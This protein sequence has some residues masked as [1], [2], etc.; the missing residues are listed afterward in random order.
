MILTVLVALNLFMVVVMRV[1]GSQ[2]YPFFISVYIWVPIYVSLVS[3]LLY[4]ENL[5]R[6]AE[7]AG[8]FPIWMTVVLTVAVRLLFVGQTESISLDAL[9]Y[10]DFGRFMQMGKIPYAG[11]YFPYPPVFAYFIFVII[12]T[13]PSVDS[14]RVL[15]ACTDGC[16]VVVLFGL[17]RQIHHSSWS[18]AIALSYALLPM[19]IIESG[20]NGHFEP[21]VV[22]LTLLSMWFVLKGRT[23]L[24]GV[25]LGL[26]VATKIYPIALLP[27]YL[28]YLKQWR[29]RIE[30]TLAIVTSIAATFIPILAVGW[31]GNGTAPPGESLSTQSLLGLLLSLLGFISNPNLVV[32]TANIFLIAAIA[33]GI[34]LT[35]FQFVRGNTLSYWHE[36]QWVMLFLGLFLVTAGLIA[37][38][39][40]L[41][42]ESRLVFWRYP[43]DVAIVRGVTIMSTG[44]VV[45]FMAYKVRRQSG[46]PE[47]SSESLL[48][49]VSATVLL[50]LALSREDFFGWYLLWSAPL[51][52]LVRN[53]RLG[54]TVLFCLL[55]AYP[56]YTHDNFVSLGFEEQ[57]LW[58][59]EFV[60][61]SGWFSRV[62]VFN[63]ELNPSQIACGSDT[64]GRYGHF[65]IN[66]T[67]IANETLL[68]NVSVSFTK[69]VYITHNTTT[70]F[71][72]RIG[73]SWDPT[74]G[75]SA[76]LSLTY[77]G[78]NSANQS[79]HGTII[80]QTTMFTNL[81]FMLWRHAFLPDPYGNQVGTI[82]NLTLTVYPYRIG[83]YEYIIDFFY[84]TQSGPLSPSG[85]LVV[86]FLTGMI[87]VAYVILRKGLSYA[88]PEPQD[89]GA[90]SSA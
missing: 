70:E 49:L 60:S 48:I 82:K 31:I 87:L 29:S 11:F 75:G 13:I 28:F 52:M 89:G 23:R 50:F 56:S 41:T 79:V 3:L 5:T 84:T 44:A 35:A 38:V 1:T 20:W 62:D 67:Q 53:R 85:L 66:T 80:Q 88:V 9:S 43:A 86:P 71:V 10:L 55:L 58:S 17:A 54:L 36:Y 42:L 59:D 73:S 39:Y 69:S 6:G 76:A 15:A 47:I 63:S 83:T 64:D 4:R 33:I 78:T 8:R 51:F 90:E 61:V 14:F 46:A 2:M 7:S 40:P 72:A 32:A 68:E 45:L 37:G 81:T 57:R 22:L 21:I 65:W 74:F 18:N 19:S 27:L 12:N 24:A 16:V 34:A 77:N 30:F 25:L 26:S